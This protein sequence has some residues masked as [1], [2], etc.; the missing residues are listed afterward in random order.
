MLYTIGEMALR[1][2]I[3]PSTLRYYDK[4]GLLPFVERTEGGIRNF[5]E[6]HFE[7]LAIIISLKESGMPIKEI[8][9]FIDFCLKGDETIHE[10][11]SLIDKQRESVLEQMKQLNLSLHVLDYKH[12]YYSTAKKAGT[13]EVPDNMPLA[14][15]P[16]EFHDIVNNFE[17]ICSRML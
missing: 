5:R 10:R 4:E 3:T 16:A 9:Q 7:W 2:G 17:S 14:D 12:W 15:I 1:L 6:D 13:C 8:R 11:L